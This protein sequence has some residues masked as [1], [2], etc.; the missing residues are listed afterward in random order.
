MAKKKKSAFYIVLV[1]GLIVLF[2]AFQFFGPVT[3]KTGKEFL[4]VR[5]GTTM[6]QLQQQLVTEKFL[7]E[8]SWFTMASKAIGFTKVKPGRYKVPR[9]TSL[10][11]LVRRLKN[12]SQTPVE[13]VVVKIRTREALAGRMGK[14]F[15]YD[16]LRAIRF[17]S[18]N[19]SLSDYGLDSNTVMAAVLPMNYEVKWNTGPRALFDKFY[20]AY[21]KFWSGARLKKAA[22]QGLTP[23]QVVTLAS[24][25]EEE[26]NVNADK[27]KIARV[28]MNRLA[29]GMPLQADPTIKFALKDFGLKRILF[30]H[31]NVISPYNT[32]KNKGL[33]PG[34]ICT[35]QLSTVEAVL[36]A[37]P[38]D[39]IYFVAN[40]NF[41]GTSVF[42]SSYQE[43]MKNAK[44]Y[45]QAL[46]AQIKK[47]DSLNALK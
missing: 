25:V 36:D 34:P 29:K 5:T 14:S 6:K 8:L 12:G 7:S 4:L 24:V 30:Q 17:L 44:M 9:G 19:D 33:P 13:F 10:V 37:P 32:Y 16:S 35:P 21:K 11:R 43:H 28:Y 23:L 42:T 46:D 39:Y 20:A 1:L 2:T 15:E 31:L 47:R 27:P 38:A 41:D 3:H 18:N 40:S 26:T 45:Q 22:A